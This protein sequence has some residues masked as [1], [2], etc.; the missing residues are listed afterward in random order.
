MIAGISIAFPRDRMNP[1]K[2]QE[3][4]ALLANAAAEL[5]ADLGYKP[6][7]PREASLV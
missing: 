1:K 4:R 7:P 6:R 3:F 5:S 2:I